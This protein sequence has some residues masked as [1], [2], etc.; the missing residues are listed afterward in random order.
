[1]NQ[2]TPPP[3]ENIEKTIERSEQMSRDLLA[4]VIKSRI[5]TPESD[6]FDVRFHVFC[7]K[8]YCYPFFVRDFPVK[9]HLFLDS[10]DQY[11]IAL[12]TLIHALNARVAFSMSECW[13]SRNIKAPRPSLASDRQEMFM[14]CLIHLKNE[15][16]IPTGKL[17]MHK[18]SRDSQGVITDLPGDSENENDVELG[19]RMTNLWIYDP[20]ESVQILYNLPTFCDALGVVLDDKVREVHNFVF[21]A[22]RVMAPDYPMLAWTDTEI[23]K[24]LEAKISV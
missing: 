14:S 16:A 5:G 18:I 19:G 3:I 4:E 2:Y 9:T 1:M 21:Q 11:I 10:H 17:I 12:K 13:M 7:P 20:R 23:S 22:K 24:M 8:G 6:I 15:D